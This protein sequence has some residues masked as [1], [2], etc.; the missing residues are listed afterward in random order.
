MARAQQIENQGIFLGGPI[1][2]FEL[3][4]RKLLMLLLN[5]GLMPDSKILDIGC[6]CLRCGYWL[7]HFLD[8][9]CYYGIEPDR[10]MLDA[11]LNVLL[12]PGLADLKQPRFD[13]NEQFDFAVFGEQFDYVIARAIWIHASKAQIQT[14]LDEFVSTSTPQA[15]FL[16]SYLPASHD[17]DDYRGATWIGRS[18]LSNQPASIRHSFNWIKAECARRRL[19]VEEITDRIFDFGHHCQIWLR[20]RHMTSSSL[21]T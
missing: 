13:E 15:I 19:I 18:R 3:A 14:M 20:I 12:E 6:G 17:D 8:R 7:I 2:Y 4:G 9:N 11:G 5:E 16:S 21:Q 1:E 10:A